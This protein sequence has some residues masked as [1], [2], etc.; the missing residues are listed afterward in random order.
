M[1]ESRAGAL[2]IGLVQMSS[3]DEA[4]RAIQQLDGFLPEGSEV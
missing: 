1:A 3:A 4:Q 2:R